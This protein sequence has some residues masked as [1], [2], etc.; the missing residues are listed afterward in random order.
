MPD[1]DKIRRLVEG[2]VPA[3]VAEGPEPTE[4]EARQIA[5]QAIQK[6]WERDHPPAPLDRLSEE[7]RARFRP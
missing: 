3:G 6:G 2:T 5:R 1:Y 4:E 7:E